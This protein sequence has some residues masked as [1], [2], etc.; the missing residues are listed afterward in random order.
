[1][2][3][4][5]QHLASEGRT[6]IK[7]IK[8]GMN[9]KRFY[10]NWDHLE[11]LNFCIRPLGGMQNSY[12]FMGLRVLTAGHL[13]CTGSQYWRSFVLPAGQLC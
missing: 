7:T 1:M 8:A 4:D 3:I 10:Y 5:K 9:S 2:L 11:Y 12:F 6:K 13:R